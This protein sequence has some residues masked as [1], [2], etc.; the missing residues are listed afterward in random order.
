[1]KVEIVPSRSEHIAHIAANIRETDRRELYDY[2]ML[3][4]QE[5]LERSFASSKLAWTGLIDGVPVAM[6]GVV[7]A[8]FLSETGRPWL[9]STTEIEKHQLTFLRRCKPV[10][11]TM[12]LCYS[13]LENF[14]AEYNTNAIAWLYWLGFKFGKP[15][16]MGAMRV[17]FIKFTMETK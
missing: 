2:M 15:E 14:V 1:L 7:P 17:P 5:A 11:K 9:I 10:V 6:F 3:T 4:P 12:T 16:P 8:S 13:R